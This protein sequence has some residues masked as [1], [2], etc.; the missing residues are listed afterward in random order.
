MNGWKYI[1]DNFLTEI[2]VI[3]EDFNVNERV[4]SVDYKIQIKYGC[5]RI[6]WENIEIKNSNGY[7][8]K[9][10]TKRMKHRLTL[11]SK[12]TETSSLTICSKCSNE[13]AK[14]TID[15]LGT[16]QV[17]CESCKNLVNPYHFVK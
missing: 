8:L 3:K 2:K 1:I 12:Q 7:V 13:N 14:L 9:L 5:L 17:L 15:N 11:L 6:K 4:I 16:Y 10:Q